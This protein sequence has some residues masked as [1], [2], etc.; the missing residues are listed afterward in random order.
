MEA[1]QPDGR[2]V[3]RLEKQCGEGGDAVVAVCDAIAEVDDVCVLPTPLLELDYLPL[4]P[5]TPRLAVHDDVR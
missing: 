3:G 4:A 1:E 2:S 5:R